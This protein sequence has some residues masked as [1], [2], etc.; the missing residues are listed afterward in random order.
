MTEPLRHIQAELDQPSF[1]RADAII[2]DTVAGQLLDA[3]KNAI[4]LSDRELQR[5]PILHPHQV[6]LRHGDI[7]EALP[8]CYGFDAGLLAYDVAPMPALRGS[9][10]Q[11]SMVVR[12]VAKADTASPPEPVG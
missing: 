9:K 3:I 12:A 8:D 10:S 4:E 2:L 11:R 1:S 7:A 5:H 6:A